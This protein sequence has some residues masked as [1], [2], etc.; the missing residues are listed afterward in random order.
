M[1]V[2]DFSLAPLSAGDYLLE[3]ATTRGSRTDRSLVAFQVGR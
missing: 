3:L 2:A 1:L